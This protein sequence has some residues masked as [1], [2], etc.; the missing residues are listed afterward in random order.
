MNE[1]RTFSDEISFIGPLYPFH[2]DILPDAVLFI[3]C[4]WMLPPQRTVFIRTLLPKHYTP[5]MLSGR[6]S[7]WFTQRYKIQLS[8][9]KENN[10]S[11]TYFPEFCFVGRLS[12]YPLLTISHFLSC[13]VTP[14]D[15]S[16]TQ[17][18]HINFR[19]H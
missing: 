1:W 16:T 14:I 10:L 6:C 15:T 13:Y 7:T 18:L 8:C 17:L 19:E 12:L 9:L 2:M 4:R 11:K 5:I 3:S